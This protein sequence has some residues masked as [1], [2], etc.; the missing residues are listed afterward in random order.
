MNRISILGSNI[1]IIDSYETA[2]T[3]I[4]AFLREIE[5]SSYVTVNNVHTIVT[6]VRDKKYRQI[7]NGSFLA[8]PMVNLYRL[9]QN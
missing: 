3:K 9:L 2:Y 5:Q 8:Y 4:L 7:I 6:A 1:S